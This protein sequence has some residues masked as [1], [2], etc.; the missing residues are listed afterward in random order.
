LGDITA[1]RPTFDWTAITGATKYK[2]I[3]NDLTTGS[4][5]VLAATTTGISWM[6]TTSLIHGHRYRWWVAA[7]NSANVGMW[8]VSKDFH[9]V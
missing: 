1:T 6:P 4:T 2:I 7:L 5:S 9:V 3:V 8:S